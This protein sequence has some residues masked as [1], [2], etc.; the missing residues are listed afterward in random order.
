MERVADVRFGD[1]FRL[2]GYDLAQAG[3]ALELTLHWQAL[4][5]PVTYYKIFVHLFDPQTQA[6][7]AQDDAVPRRWTYPTTWWEAGEV[8]SDEI[9]LSLEEVPPGQYR[10]AVGVYDPEDGERLV[11]VDAAGE[12]LPEGRLVLPEEVVR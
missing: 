8:V 11:V 10:L 7:V 2:L 9:P 12:E 6:V 5:H 1:D 3:D 4:R